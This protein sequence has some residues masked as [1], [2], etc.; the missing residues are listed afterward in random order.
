MCTTPRRPGSRPS[1]ARTTSRPGAAPR[2]SRAS[3]GRGSARPWAA[4]AVPFGVVNAPGQ[5]YHP[6]IVAQAMATLLELFP[7][8]LWVAMGSGEASNEHI[9]GDRWP[10]KTIRNERVPRVRRHR[11][12][13]P[14]RRGGQLRRSCPRRSGAAVDAPPSVPPIYG[15]ALTAETAELCGAWA[16]GLLTVGLP[17]AE[18]TRVIEAFRGGGGDGKP[19]AVQAKVAYAE[20][21]EEAVAGAFEQWRTNVFESA[22]MADLETVEQF[23]IAARHVPPG[24]GRRRGPLFGGRRPPPRVPVRPA[25][26]RRRPPLRAPRPPAAARVHRCLRREGR[27]GPPHRGSGVMSIRATSDQWW[28]GAVVYCLDAETFLDWDGDGIGDF[29][30]LTERIDYLAG[31]GDQRPLAHA[32]L[33]DPRPRRRLRR[34][35]LLRRRPEARHARR[36]RRSRADRRGPRHARSSST[37]S[38][39][40]PPTSTRG[41]G[42]PGRAATRRYRDWY[43]WVDEPPEG[44]E[45][46]EVFPGEQNGTWTYD[47][48]AGQYYL[49]R[50]FDHQPD[51][52]IANVE[53]RQE[54]ARII[55]FWLEL[56]VAGFR[57]DAVPFLLELHGIESATDG[58]DPHQYLKELRAFLS[59]P[60]RRCHPPRRGQPPAAGPAHVL[61]RR[62][63]RRTAPRL[64]VLDHAAHLPVDGAPGRPSPRGGRRRAAARALR[65]ASGRRSCATTTS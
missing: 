25:R 17:P 24:G 11:A 31:L 41:S 46:E 63:R 27:A 61:R 20:T 34:H 56:G 14:P 57:V 55:G 60:P 53:V 40:T 64:P 22:L 58:P 7:D 45:L 16:D 29:A 15:A 47:D 54:I 12:R 10:P 59:A 65:L 6:A 39:T 21:D 3:P 4:T 30:G 38:S 52:N 8:R 37:S 48:E 44:Q 28:K 49:H 13:P 51:L 42:R 1:R 18:L 33:P 43:V 2:A 9:T 50:F 19:V 62:G 32:V 23:E 36:V 5:R 35:R 26:L